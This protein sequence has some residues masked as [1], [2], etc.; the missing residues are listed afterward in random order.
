[1]L[2]A[3]SSGGAGSGVVGRREVVCARLQAVDALLDMQ[4]VVVDSRGD[5]LGEVVREVVGCVEARVAC[6]IAPP[7]PVFGTARKEAEAPGTGAP[8]ATESLYYERH[9]LVAL[10]EPRVVVVALEEGYS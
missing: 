3:T 10:V 4:R 9:Y 5:D 1:M 2:G 7:L 6:A 8:N